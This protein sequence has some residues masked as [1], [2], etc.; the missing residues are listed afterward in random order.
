MKLKNT[1]HTYCK[2]KSMNIV[3]DTAHITFLIYSVLPQTSK[4]R[5]NRT[6]RVFSFYLYDL[7][8]KEKIKVSP[9]KYW[10]DRNNNYDNDSLNVDINMYKEVT[11]TIDITNLGLSNIQES[12]WV[13]NC[14]VIIHEE[15]LDEDLW[16]SED[17]TLVSDIIPMPKITTEIKANSGHITIS[18]A[19][20]LSPEIKVNKLI[21][22]LSCSIKIKTIYNQT[23]ETFITQL[24]TTSL[25]DPI[26]VT[27]E[28]TYTDPVIIVLDILNIKNNKLLT[29]SNFFN[30]SIQ[31]IK[32]FVLTNS[33]LKPKAIYIKRDKTITKVKRISAQ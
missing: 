8:T 19:F 11:L 18:S 5:F 3:E 6:T 25:H 1:D 21:K 23:L 12:R 30:P 9:N 22:T 31:D 14:K 26:V 27:S 2:I 28:N 4:D 17:L 16:V 33:V 32:A 13:R 29:Y 20:T 7:D 15:E 10:I 24:N